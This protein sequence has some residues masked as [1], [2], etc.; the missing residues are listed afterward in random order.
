MLLSI[1][2]YALLIVLLAMSNWDCVLLFLSWI[3]S[4]ASRWLTTPTILVVYGLVL[5]Y[6]LLVVHGLATAHEK[7]QKRHKNVLVPY[8]DGNGQLQG[9]VRDT[10]GKDPGT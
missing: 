2:G 9:W 6:L 5:I 8:Y 3:Y 4:L 7:R 10:G 1:F